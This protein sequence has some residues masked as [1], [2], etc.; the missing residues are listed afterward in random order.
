MFC[1]FSKVNGVSSSSGFPRD[2]IH[3]G[4]IGPLKDL[5]LTRQLLH[6]TAVGSRGCMESQ[7]IVDKYETVFQGNMHSI[8]KVSTTHQS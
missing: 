2:Q 6:P 3:F 1:E 4:H 8:K 5:S 7:P